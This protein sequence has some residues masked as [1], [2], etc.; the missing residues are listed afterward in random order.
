MPDQGTGDIAVLGEAAIGVWRE[1]TVERLQHISTKNIA[2]PAMSAK[3]K[4]Q[5]RFAV[6]VADASV[7]KLFPVGWHVI[8]V[9][10]GTAEQAPEHF[11]V[12]DVLYIERIRRDLKET[13]LRRV[14]ATEAARMRLATH[15]SDAK[16]KNEI[17]Y[18]PVN[19][20]VEKIVLLGKVVGRYGDYPG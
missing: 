12:D 6:K 1:T 2:V 16:L 14:S 20:S 5:R 11:A 3:R 15:S 8:C 7:D 18:P 13:S 10:L 19:G 4:G 17:T 9:A